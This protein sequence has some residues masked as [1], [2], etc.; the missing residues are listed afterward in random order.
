MDTHDITRDRT[1]V[2]LL[3]AEAHPDIS[4]L[5]HI[6][7]NCT[8]PALIVSIDSDMLFPPEQQDLLATY[9]PDAQLVKL[10]SSDGHDGFLLELE[11]TDEMIRSFLQRHNPT[12]FAAPPSDSTEEATPVEVSLH[13]IF[14]EVDPHFQ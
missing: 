14:G 3:P 2:A 10:Q 4:S 1:D 7:G 13:S 5:A 8:T 9:L 12:A 11:A 6:L